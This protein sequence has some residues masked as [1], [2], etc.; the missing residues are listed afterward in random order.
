MLNKVLL[1]GRLTR[2]VAVVGD[3]NKVGF[4]TIACE[5]NF[6]NKEGKRDTDFVSVKVYGKILE[7]VEKY[8][9]KGNAIQIEAAIRTYQKEVDGKNITVQDIVATGVSF[10]IT[11]KRGETAAAT[12][13]APATDAPADDD[14]PF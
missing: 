8:F 13:E 14:L 6:K 5:R 10:P 12:P 3:E 11:E 2:D 7:H 1:E 4:L 9:K